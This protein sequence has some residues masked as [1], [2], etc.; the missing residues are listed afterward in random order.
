VRCKGQAASDL[1]KKRTEERGEAQRKLEELKARTE[2]SPERQAALEQQIDELKSLIGRLG[3]SIR[4]ARRRLRKAG[5]EPEP[6]RATED[7]ATR[8]ARE[9]EAIDHEIEKLKGELE[10]GGDKAEIQRRLN[11]LKDKRRPVMARLVHTRIR[12]KTKLGQH[13]PEHEQ[14]LKLAE[15]D[16]E[17]VKR[18][19]EATKRALRELDDSTPRS[20]AEK[21]TASKRKAELQKRLKWQEA[22]LASADQILTWEREVVEL[23]ELVRSA[24][25][26]GKGSAIKQRISELRT[27]ITAERDRKRSRNRMRRKRADPE[28]G[29]EFRAA[30]D[31]AERARLRTGSYVADSQRPR[32]PVDL[33]TEELVRLREQPA[34]ASRDQRIAYLT[35]AVQVLE[36]LAAIRRKEGYDRA[37]LAK[38]RAR[39][40][41]LIGQGKDTSKADQSIAR[42]A[43]RQ[44]ARKAERKRLLAQTL[45]L[46]LREVRHR[47]AGQ[48][49]EEA[50]LRE[51]EQLLGDATTFDEQRLNQLERELAEMLHDESEPLDAEFFE[52]IWREAEAQDAAPPAPEPPPRSPSPARAAAE[53]SGFRALEDELRA[54]R[55]AFESEDM[56]LAN[57]HAAQSEMLPGPGSSRHAAG[58]QRLE[59][60]NAARLQ[61]RKDWRQQMQNRLDTA[62]QRLRDLQSN[63]QWRDEAV[64]ADLAQ[65]IALLEHEVQNPSF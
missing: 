29:E 50:R 18:E 3:E 25:T 49:A 48:G 65:Q 12:E 31:R 7:A 9:L 23:V 46:G 17:A 61:L 2:T 15:R 34:S 62:R 30:E 5:V 60:L 33:M 13:V 55:S 28:H 6:K 27:K 53:E 56:D 54:E 52:Q 44:E 16:H 1:L 63:P 41:E 26:E 43:Q 35:E 32:D 37:N 40:E 38:A 59:A 45:L 21:E 36:A 8:N 14:L 24:S 47:K 20:D 64:E 39:R 58:M 42:I 22:D 11:E 19:L 51:L 10:S 4:D 57:Q